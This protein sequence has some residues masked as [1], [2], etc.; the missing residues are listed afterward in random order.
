MSKRQRRSF[1]PE[2]KLEAAQLVVDNG[3]TIKEACDAMNIGSSSLERWVSQLRQERQGITPQG[4]AL[5]EDQKKIKALEKRIRQLEEHNTILKKASA[6][7]MSDA[8]NK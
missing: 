3:Y 1:S 2:F 7:L 4:K 6:L 5:T 8:L